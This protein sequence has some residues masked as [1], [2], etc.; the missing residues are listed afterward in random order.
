[1]F[2]ALVILMGVPA[3]SRVNRLV[4]FDRSLVIL[5]RSSFYWMLLLI[6]SSWRT[7]GFV[8]YNSKSVLLALDLMV[9]L[10]KEM[11]M[12]VGLMKQEMNSIAAAKSLI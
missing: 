10:L 8:L 6:T 9:L 2:L 4:V 11:P 3:M 7:A 1:M 12:K 5:T